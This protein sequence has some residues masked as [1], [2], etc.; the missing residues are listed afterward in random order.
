MEV[1]GA[2]SGTGMGS[3]RTDWP[4]TTR[5]W[6]MTWASTSS[7]EGRDFRRLRNSSS[8]PGMVACAIA[9]DMRSGSAKTISKPMT[10]APIAVRR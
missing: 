9:G 7:L 5:L 8:R 10:M 6:R 1:T 3:L 2:F 4:I